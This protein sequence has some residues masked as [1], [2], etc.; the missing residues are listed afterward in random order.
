MS[1]HAARK[2]RTILGNAQNVIG[3]ELLAAAQAADWRI[4]MDISPSNPDQE[5]KQTVAEAQTQAEEFRAVTAQWEKTIA[6]KLA[7]RLQAVYTAI[8]KDV[9][10]ITTDQR[11]DEHVRKVCALVKSGALRP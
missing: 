1:T 10:P 8:R 2:L 9:K 4:G 6:P 3:I 5:R 7:P 11:L